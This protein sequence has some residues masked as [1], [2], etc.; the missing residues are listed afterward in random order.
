MMSHNLIAFL[1]MTLILVVAWSYYFYARD[2]PHPYNLKKSRLF[3][4][5]YPARDSKSVDNFWANV[6]VNS[7]QIWSLV[8]IFKAIL[9]YFDIGVK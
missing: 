8:I 7:L 1:F 5:K 6:A 3:C 2:L 4:K 9:F